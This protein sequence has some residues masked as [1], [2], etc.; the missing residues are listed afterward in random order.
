MSAPSSISNPPTPNSHTRN[1]ISAATTHSPS[2]FRCRCVKSRTE[3]MNSAPIFKVFFP[4]APRL[5]ALPSNNAFGRTTIWEYLPAA[6]SIASE[7]SCSTREH[8]M[9]MP[10]I[11]PCTCLSFLQKRTASQYPRNCN[12]NHGFRSQERNRRP[13]FSTTR[14]RASTKAGISRWVEPPQTTS[15]NTQAK[16]FP[17]LS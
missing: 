16:T 17:I 1:H 6:A 4:K 9:S 5:N 12:R 11:C 10:P 3:K 15:S 8:R 7:M 14:A 13:A 2:P